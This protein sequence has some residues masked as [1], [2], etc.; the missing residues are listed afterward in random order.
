MNGILVY[1]CE[2]IKGIL[3]RNDVAIP[4]IEYCDGWRDFANMG[5][6]VI[7]AYDYEDDRYRVFLADNFDEFQTLVDQRKVIIGFN[8]LAFD[9]H[10]CEANDINVPDSKSWD[11]LVETWKGAGLGPAFQ[12]PSHAGYGLNAVAGANIGQHKSGHGALAP[13]LWQ[14]GKIGQVVDY[15]LQDVALTKKLFDRVIQRESL[16]NPKTGAYL[17]VRT[18]HIP[19]IFR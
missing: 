16:V 9:N 11:L 4:G 18:P 13:V 5:I 15:C 10:L 7:G 17:V 19:E 1:D 2:I 8:S 6:S 12:Y 3:G 14:Q